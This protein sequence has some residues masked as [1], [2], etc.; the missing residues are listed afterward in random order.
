MAK[1]SNFLTDTASFFVKRHLI[2]LPK[3]SKN[4]SSSS[5][6]FILL[7]EVFL[8]SRNFSDN[9]LTAQNIRKGS[10]A[11]RHRPAQE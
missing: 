4:V 7:D 11:E 6:N 5:L 8:P 1:N 10:V 3:F 9:F 2:L